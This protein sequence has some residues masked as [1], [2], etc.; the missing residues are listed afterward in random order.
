MDCLPER[1]NLA[2]YRQSEAE[3]VSLNTHHEPSRPLKTATKWA[4]PA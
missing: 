4:T 2:R 1:E 3:A